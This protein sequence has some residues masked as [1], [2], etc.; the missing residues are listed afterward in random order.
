M[1]RAFTNTTSTLP[2]K[3]LWTGRQYIP[4]L[5]IATTG[6]RCS[7]NH[8]RKRNNSSVNVPKSSMAYRS[9]PASPG[10]TTGRY[11][12]LMNIQP[13]TYGV[14]NT[15]NSAIIPLSHGLPPDLSFVGNPSIRGFTVTHPSTATSII[16]ILRCAQN[17]HG[18]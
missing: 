4:V 17:G 8:D 11:A 1:S 3:T 12:L 9:S 14:H 15:D 6:Q 2:S 16:F 10:K 7:N 5:S 18:G 13:A